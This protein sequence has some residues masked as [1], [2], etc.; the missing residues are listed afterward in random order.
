MFWNPLVCTRVVHRTACQM[1]FSSGDAGWDAAGL[2][3]SCSPGLAF[4]A[5]A[6][7]MSVQK[8]SSQFARWCY[9]RYLVEPWTVLL[10]L[11][12][13]S[14]YIF[15]WNSGN[16]DFVRKM[17]HSR[18]APFC[19]AYLHW[20]RCSV[21]NPCDSDVSY[22]HSRNILH[23]W[24]WRLPFMFSCGCWWFDGELVFYE[25]KYGIVEP[26]FSNSLLETFTDDL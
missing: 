22:T 23:I 20:L 17:T 2:K 24:E 16:L 12:F 3:F 21:V 4:Y 19:E 18:T 14:K 5:L 25:I 1:R 11:F 6:Q 9:K 7:F 15:C 10:G 13:T 26:A 8:R